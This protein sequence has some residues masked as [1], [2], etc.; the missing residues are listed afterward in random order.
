MCRVTPVTAEIGFQF[1]GHREL[2]DQVLQQMWNQEEE[3]RVHPARIRLCL[4]RWEVF[5]TMLSSTSLFERVCIQTGTRGK[6]ETDFV[7]FYCLSQSA[8]Y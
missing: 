1:L 5:R 4:R 2:S 8:F 3:I 6:K 7:F